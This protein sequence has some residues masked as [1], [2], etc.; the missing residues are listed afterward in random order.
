MGRSLPKNVG[1]PP[2]YTGILKALADL[3]DEQHA[4]PIDWFGEDFDYHVVD[5]EIPT[6][7]HAAENR[8]QHKQQSSPEVTFPPVL[9]QS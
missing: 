4:E 5:I 2:G 3:E 1:E 9:T 8:R 6:A 7:S